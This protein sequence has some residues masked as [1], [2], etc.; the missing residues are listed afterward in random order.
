MQAKNLG[1]QSKT[2]LHTYTFINYIY[3]NYFLFKW[4]YCTQFLSF[5]TIKCQIIKSYVRRL[6]L[7]YISDWQRI[8]KQEQITFWDILSTT[9]L[10]SST[11][12]LTY[13]LERSIYAWIA[14]KM[15]IHVLYVLQFISPCVR[16]YCTFEKVVVKAIHFYIN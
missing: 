3:Y 16:T 15:R 13:S 1:V 8:L 10:Q 9:Y 12:F 7:E 6:R 2:E 5:S 14:N 11:E 4:Y